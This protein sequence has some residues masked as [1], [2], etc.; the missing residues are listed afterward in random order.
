MVRQI[1]VD[2]TE[3]VYIAA[4]HE[5]FISHDAGDSWRRL[6]GDLPTV[7]ALAVV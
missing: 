5:Q 6:A 3:T 7:K 4:G 1:A 2:D